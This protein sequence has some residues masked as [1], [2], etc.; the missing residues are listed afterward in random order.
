MNDVVDV[1]YSNDCC[2]VVVNEG[3][4]NVITHEH[5]QND[6]SHTEIA[7]LNTLVIFELK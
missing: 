7:S 2:H 5:D 1:Q 6:C 3:K 4:S